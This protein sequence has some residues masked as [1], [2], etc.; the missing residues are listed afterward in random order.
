[1]YTV[2]QL[3][4]QS[5]AAAHVVRYYLRI[6][7]IEPTSQQQ[8]GYRLFAPEQASRLRFIRLAKQLGFTLGEIRQI[9]E[10]SER[11][12]SPCQDVRKIIQDRIEENR[13]K[14]DEMIQL[15][16]R[17]E[18]ALAQWQTMPD[19]EPDGHSVCHLIES[20]EESSD[21]DVGT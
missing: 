17:M 2:N 3:A 6:G 18:S 21:D 12:E 7:L 15:Q 8:N 10:H 9:L 4:K 16:G 19:G 13:I 20:F 11:H 1:M 5:N 14:I